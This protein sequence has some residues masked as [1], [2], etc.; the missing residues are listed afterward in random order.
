MDSGGDEAGCDAVDRYPIR[1]ER[2]GKILGQPRDGRFRGRVRVK[3]RQRRRGPTAAERDDRSLACA[4]RGE[5]GVNRQLGPEE[6]DFDRAAECA[7]WIR[8]DHADRLENGSCCHE[9]GQFVEIYDVPTPSVFIAH[10]EC[11]PAMAVSRQRSACLL[12]GSGSARNQDQPGAAPCQG[13][14]AL[15]PYSA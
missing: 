1:R 14:S 15:E 4:Q 3:A 8:P 12:Q 7:G 6:V 11:E 9:A 2:G 5:A 10:V 13:S